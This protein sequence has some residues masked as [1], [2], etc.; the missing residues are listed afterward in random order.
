[1][2]S[3][4]N[5]HI[6]IYTHTLIILNYIKRRPFFKWH[7][8]PCVYNNIFVYIIWSV[9]VVHSVLPPHV[10]LTWSNN[11]YIYT[12]VLRIP[13]YNIHIILYTESDF[14]I[15]RF[16]RTD[17]IKYEFQNEIIISSRT[18]RI[19]T[20]AVSCIIIHIYLMIYIIL[21]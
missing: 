19:M 17:A 6:G 9:W 20:R 7:V 12:P 8:H 18:F 4:Q 13:I 10:N 15:Y 14:N 2:E 16:N 3:E 1:M 21:L 11:S 5:G